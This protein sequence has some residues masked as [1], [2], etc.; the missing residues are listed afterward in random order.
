[1]DAPNCYIITTFNAQSETL[2]CSS[3]QMHRLS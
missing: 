2:P 1:M 3:L